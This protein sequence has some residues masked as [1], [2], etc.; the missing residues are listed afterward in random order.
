MSEKLDDLLDKLAI[1][2][3]EISAEKGKLTFFGLFKRSSPTESWILIVSSSWSDGDGHPDAIDYI[4]GKYYAVCDDSER[5]LIARVAIVDTDDDALE[6]LLEAYDVE[7]GRV[8]IRK[9]AM[10]MRSSNAAIFL[11]AN[12]G[13]WQRRRTHAGILPINLVKDFRR[14]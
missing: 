12:G 11:P 4:V 9:N 7:H 8:K 13:K 1:I 2:E 5:V 14:T 6:D 10:S 3:G